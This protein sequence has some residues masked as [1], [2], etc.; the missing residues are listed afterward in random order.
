M[1]DKVVVAYRIKETDKHAA[2]HV[3][4][5]YVKAEYGVV[6]RPIIIDGPQKSEL[7]QMPLLVRPHRP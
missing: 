6:L 2:Y 3:Q 7:P 4:P 1:T 5:E